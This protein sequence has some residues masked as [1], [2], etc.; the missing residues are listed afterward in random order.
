MHTRMCTHRNA[1]MYTSCTHVYTYTHAHTN[2][3]V[4]TH[5]CTHMHT[6]S[7]HMPILTIYTHAH[8]GEKHVSE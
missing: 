4:C 1:H 8:A 6:Q 7:V 5:E 3:R 2:A